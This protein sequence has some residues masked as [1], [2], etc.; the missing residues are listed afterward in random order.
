MTLAAFNH[1]KEYIGLKEIA[2]QM[3]NPMVLRFFK[4]VGHGWVKD[5][6]TAWCAAFVGAV[7]S[8][9]GETGTGKINARSYLKWGYD[10]PFEKA[11]RGDI[12]V[13]WRGQP[14]TAQGHVAFFD[15]WDAIGNPIVL[16]GNQ[17]NSVSLQ[18]YPRRR[19]LSVRAAQPR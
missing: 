13:F 11:Q 16:G 18:A 12:V 2:G 14:N 6:E 15:S 10:V 4:L 8:E 9:V 3:H 1:A 7:L 5:D 17:G 19:M